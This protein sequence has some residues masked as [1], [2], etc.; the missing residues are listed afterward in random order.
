MSWSFMLHKSKR[1]MKKLLAISVLF[2]VLINCTK[3]SHKE[4][5]VSDSIEKSVNVKAKPPST[6]QEILIVSEP[7]AL[8]YQPDSLQ[9]EKIKAI[10]ETRIFEA[11][12]HDFLYQRKYAHKFLKQYWPRLKI[13]YAKNVRFLAFIKKDGSL[14]TIDLNK[15]G[16]CY[17]LIVF[18]RIKCP[19][20]IDM[21]NIDTQVPEYF[22]KRLT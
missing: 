16:D 15:L 14:E 6:F 1:Y 17:G 22:K 9:K 12:M 10:T 5:V 4:T 19:Q 20:Q 3:T 8:F 13:I 21:T 7:C 18:N 2:M 11:S